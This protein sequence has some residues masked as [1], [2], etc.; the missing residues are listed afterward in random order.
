ML[1]IY[2]FMKDLKNITILAYTFVKLWSI[3]NILGKMFTIW[4]RNVDIP[5]YVYVE[6]SGVFQ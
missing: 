6:H 4:P 1:L 2:H 5:E 3:I